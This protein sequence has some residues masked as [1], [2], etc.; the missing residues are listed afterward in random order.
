MNKKIVIVYPFATGEKAF[1][2]GVPKVI[3][4]NIIAVKMNGDIPY[5][6]LPLD[7]AGLIS[8][9][10][11][12]LPYCIVKPLDFKTL[13]L[14]I[15]IKNPLRR[16][17]M[18]ARNIIGY[19]KGKHLIKEFLNSVQ[20]DVIHYHDAVLFPML[21]LYK[22]AR[23][24]MHIH[25]YRF[26]SFGIG[27]KLICHYFNK[28]ADEIISPTKSIKNA[29]QPLIKNEIEIV[30]T[31]YLELGKMETIA[32]N[33]ILV[34][35]KKSG[36][37]IFTFVGRI[38]RIKRI[39]HFLKAL[40]CLTE[41]ER[42]KMVFVVIG[43]CNTTGDEAYKNEMMSFIKESNISDAVNFIGYVNPI[44]SALKCVD[45]GTLLT[46]SEAMPMVGIEYMR[47]NIPMIGYDAP[48]I[49]DF[50]VTNENGYLLDNGNIKAITDVLRK[51]IHSS[52]LV[53]M[54]KSIEKKFEKHSIANFAK[55]LNAIYSS[56][57]S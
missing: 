3:V 2:G 40:A 48:G 12:N 4:S 45:Y 11:E 57:V 56:T 8:Y 39:D 55:S 1:S 26:T 33:P 44:E 35:Y 5:L 52:D 16:A 42:S 43:G 50:L 19:V 14:Y 46:E 49:N 22:N 27:L 47:F 53:D 38:C 18:V 37:I 24:V 9:V 15:D 41:E 21:G 17:M 23:K 29:I 10:K 54:S 6:I 13:S 30:E 7:N 34:Q 20:P 51:I 36:K 31:P 28:N 32:P 25:T